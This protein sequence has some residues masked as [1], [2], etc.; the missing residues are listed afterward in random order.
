MA[1]AR[2]PKLLLS[3][4]LLMAVAA[5]GVDAQEGT[6]AL[7][8]GGAP[9]KAAAAQ[10]SRD[11]Q[12]G[13]EHRFASGLTISVSAPQSFQPSPA[14][15]PRSPR[16]ASF[17]IEITNNGADSYRLSGFT[18][19]AMI[20]GRPTK[21]VVDATQGLGGITDAGKDLQQGRSAQLTLAF[22]VPDRTT[23]LTVQLRPSASE[24]AVATYCGAV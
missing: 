13:A 15:Y 21:Q 1:P 22:A 8:G 10:T 14:A 5:C 2:T 12:F 9:A 23:Q 24:P 18:V 20:E 19:V 11:L 3:A 4:C 17:G 6:A 16:A 7:G